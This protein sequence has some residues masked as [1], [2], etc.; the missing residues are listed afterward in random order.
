M[1]LDYWTTITYQERNN[2]QYLNEEL[3]VIRR[4][5]CGYI[6]IIDA[7]IQLSYLKL[8]YYSQSDVFFKPHLN[9]AQISRVHGITMGI[10]CI[11]NPIYNCEP[12]PGQFFTNSFGGP[13]DWVLSPE[14]DGCGPL[15]IESW[16]AELTTIGEGRAPHAEECTGLPIPSQEGCLI[17]EFA[18]GQSGDQRPHL[19]EVD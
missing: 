9:T 10:P 19:E 4:V 7:V 15:V 6:S 16:P 18:N 12:T 14:G 13:P 8:L 1:D 3:G 2:N 17:S 5:A 11:N